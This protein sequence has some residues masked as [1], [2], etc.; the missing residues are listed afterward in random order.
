MC[1]C[2]HAVEFGPNR[3]QR[4]LRRRVVGERIESRRLGFGSG[5]IAGVGAEG[6]YS[7]V[8]IRHRRG[9][10]RNF[11]KYS[12]MPRLKFCSSSVVPLMMGIWLN[13][14]FSMA[15]TN[16]SGRTVPS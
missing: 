11:S 13:W 10:A 7:I 6:S 2:A 12:V 9:N 16:L 3:I 14:P 15:A 8:I 5:R 1:R 4:Q